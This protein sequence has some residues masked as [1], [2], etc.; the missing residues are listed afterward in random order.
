MSQISTLELAKYLDEHSIE[1][2]DKIAA[3]RL[4]ALHNLVQ[5]LAFQ[6]GVAVCYV[7]DA[8]HDESYKADR[9]QKQLAGMKSAIQKAEV[10]NV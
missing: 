4:K 6:L 10:E 8:Q 2:A 3:E 7:E 1:Q 9:V 5:E